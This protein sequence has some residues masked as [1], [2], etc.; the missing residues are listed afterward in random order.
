MTELLAAILG[1][2]VG[3]VI[4]PILLQEYRDW[5]HGKTWAKPRRTRLEGMLKDRKVAPTGWRTISRLCLETG[6]EAE[7][8]RTLLIEIGARGGLIEENNQEVE[9][10]ILDDP[11]T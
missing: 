2:L 5:K 10:W 9:A 8:C 6:M 7:D 1:G 11:T 4:G 3:G